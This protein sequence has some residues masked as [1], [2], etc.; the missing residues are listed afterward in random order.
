M[1]G[2]GSDK[3][4]DF[5]RLAANQKKRSA[6][7]NFGCERGDCS[8]FGCIFPVMHGRMLWKLD[9]SAPRMICKLKFENNVRNGSPS[10]PPHPLN[11]AKLK[12]IWQGLGCDLQTQVGTCSQ[13]FHISP[14]KRQPTIIVLN[15]LHLVNFTKLN[16]SLVLEVPLKWREM[17]MLISASSCRGTL[18]EWQLQGWNNQ[19]QRSSQ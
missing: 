15:F 17:W 16:I 8:N 14:G 7:F 12:Q 3:K 6:N 19:T 1:I 18:W 5:R 2:P 11:W 13:L 10:R 4:G 9:G